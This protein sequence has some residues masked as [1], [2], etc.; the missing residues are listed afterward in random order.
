MVLIH[1]VG[2][3][4]IVGYI[5]IVDIMDKSLGGLCSIRKNRTTSSH[6]RAGT[7]AGWLVPT[8]QLVCSYCMFG[9]SDL[10]RYAYTVYDQ[11]KG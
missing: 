6:D 2:I 8:L 5:D 11:G 1:I 3:V 7:A 10:L 9:K 4:G